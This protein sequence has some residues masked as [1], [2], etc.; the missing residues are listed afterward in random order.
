MKAHPLQLA[1]RADVGP[2]LERERDLDLVT[3]E[4]PYRLLA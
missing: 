1:A 3:K 2:F 4:V